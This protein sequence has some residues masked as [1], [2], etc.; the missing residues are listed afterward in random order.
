MIE[1]NQRIGS[2]ETSPITLDVD[3]IGLIEP[4]DSGLTTIV[5]QNG[6]TLLADLPYSEV[7]RMVIEARSQFVTVL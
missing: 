6:R 7:R 1:F 4:V 5:L 2:E 3:A